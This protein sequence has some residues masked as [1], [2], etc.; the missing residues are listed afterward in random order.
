MAERMAPAHPYLPALGTGIA[1]TPGAVIL[2]EGGKAVETARHRTATPWE[3]W[4]GL[5]FRE[6]FPR[7]THWWFRGIWTGRVR[8]SLPDE[9]LTQGDAL[10]GWVTFDMFDLPRRP[11]S[12]ID[13][14]PLAVLP[15]YPPLEEQPANMAL[16]L[17][18]ARLI[19][20][21]IRGEV[22]PETWLTITSLVPRD[23]LHA[24]FPA[25]HEEAARVFGGWRLAEGDEPL[26]LPVREALCRLLGLEPALELAS[27]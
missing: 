26:R 10:V 7:V 24:F 14:T 3:F 11:Y 22:E 25:T 5:S 9:A 1:W 4:Q 17:S 12:V 19:V 2:Y 21:V 23:R 13:E 6:T 27:T 16:R 20:G 18:I 8:V 15:P